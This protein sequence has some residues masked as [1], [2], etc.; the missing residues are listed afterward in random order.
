MEGKEI[1]KLPDLCHRST[2]SYDL[3]LQLLTDS[4]LAFTQKN[5]NSQNQLAEAVLNLLLVNKK[6]TEKLSH[7]KF[8]TAKVIWNIG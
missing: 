2:T 3:T 8:F 4:N 7:A 1:L 5:I 6:R